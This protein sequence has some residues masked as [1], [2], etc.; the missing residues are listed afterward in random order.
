MLT[1]KPEKAWKNIAPKPDPDRLLTLD[2]RNVGAVETTGPG[3]EYAFDADRALIAAVAPKNDFTGLLRTLEG[4]TPEDAKELFAAFGA[5]LMDR[6]AVT[7]ERKPDRGWE[8]IQT[9]A[10]QTGISFPHVLQA[11]AELFILCSRPVDK[12]A[13][14][15]SHT[16]VM[17]IQQYTCAY[18]AAQREAG[19]SAE[20]LPCREL[21]L[22]AFR[23]AA[24]RRGMP[25]RVELTQALSEANACEFTFTPE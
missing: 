22:S 10:K 17:R 12:W 19:C 6:V 21:C 15:E 23:R 14:V 9:C 5:G 3:V 18:L 1:G 11:Y 13:V 4:T 20:G 7:A 2:P 25:V 8:M 16:G 24:D